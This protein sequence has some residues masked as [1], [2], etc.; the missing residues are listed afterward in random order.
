MISE[1]LARRL[2]PGEEPL[3]RKVAYVPV[4]SQAVEWMEVISIVNEV[5]PV[6]HDIGEA[7]YVYTSLGQDLRPSAGSIIAK[8]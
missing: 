7:P 2:W 8:G 6:L 1:A 3:G 5:N 4:P